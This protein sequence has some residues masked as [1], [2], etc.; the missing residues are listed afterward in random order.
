M[1]HFVRGVRVVFVMSLM[2]TKILAFGWSA[3]QRLV[4]GIVVGY[5]AILSVHSSIKE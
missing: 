4:V 5:P 2:A 3:H 1:M